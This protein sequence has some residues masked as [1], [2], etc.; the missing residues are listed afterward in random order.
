[1]DNEKLFELIDNS[2]RYGLA[3]RLTALSFRN[4]RYLRRMQEIKEAI[5]AEFYLTLN[6]FGKTPKGT[7]IIAEKFTNVGLVEL[8]STSNYFP[9]QHV[10]DDDTREYHFE[11]LA[12]RLLNYEKA[13]RAKKVRRDTLKRLG[14]TTS[15]SAE[16]LEKAVAYEESKLQGEDSTSNDNT[17]EGA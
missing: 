15:M 4:K 1:M 7:P 10:M 11:Y 3:A 12:T 9:L 5:P 13:A 2:E 8:L 17:D 6:E 14:K 16:F